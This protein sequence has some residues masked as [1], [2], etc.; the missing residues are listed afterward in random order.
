MNNINKKPQQNFFKVKGD[1]YIYIYL[2]F[3]DIK[4]CEY[5]RLYFDTLW[6]E[7]IFIL[8]LE[9]NTLFSYLKMVEDFKATF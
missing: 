2:I 8:V 7:K 9:T 4:L 6:V 1:I 5:F 3:L